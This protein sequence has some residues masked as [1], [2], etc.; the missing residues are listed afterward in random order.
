VPNGPA[1]GPLPLLL[2]H[3]ESGLD[4]E[5]GATLHV[6]QWK[7]YLSKNVL[8]G[9]VRAFASADVHVRVESFRHIDEAVARINDPSADFDVVFPTIG[10]LRGLV[11]A[12]L[13]LPLNHDYLPNI[14]N[15][16]SWFRGDG[17]FFDPQ[18]R[19]STPYT[20][21]S[22]GVGWRA[23][24]VAPN[25]APD[26]Q[27]DPFAIFW[28]TRYRGELGMYDEYLEAL[29]LSLL[30]D[31]VIDLHAAT[32]AQLERAA[33][34]LERAVRDAGVRFTDDGA[35][36]GLPQGRFV[37]HQAWSGDVLTAERYARSDPDAY[38][39]LQSLRYCAPRGRRLVV[40]CDLTAICAKAR[41]PVLAHAFLN[42]LLAFDVAMD[43]FSW[44]GYQPPLDG[45]SPEAFADPTFRWHRAVP[46]HL[47]DAVLTPDTFA[48]GQMLDAFAPSELA[49]WV[50]QWNRVAL[51]RQTVISH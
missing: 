30:H 43:N 33:D 46:P 9:F 25:D 5:R 44:N 50:E 47:L 2:D 51:A 37:A 13:L 38:Q 48:N 20:V 24:L 36:E 27:P 22:S 8:A 39:A 14:T 49:P 11:N 18:L 26:A 45:V 23:D 21:Y 35:A 1:P 34:G 41:S 7:N 3:I 12:R 42:H 28:N 17:P 31:G 10:V 40:G 19:Y 16:W 29:S 15:L 32:D 4:V 6:Y